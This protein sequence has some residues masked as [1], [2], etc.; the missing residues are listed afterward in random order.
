VIV[1]ENEP[2]DTRLARPLDQ[3]GFGLD[4][5]WN[6]D[7]HHSAM[8]ALTGRAEA[9]YSDTKGDVQELISA[10]K[11]GYLFQG[12]HYHW[13]RKPRGTPSRGLAPEAFVNYLQNHDQVANSARGL[14]G[15]QLTSPGAWRAMTALA[16][17]MPGTPM[18]FQGQE[19]SA[20]APFLYFA[21]HDPELAELV[22]KGRAEF[23]RQFPS[24]ADYAEKRALDDPADPDTFSRCVL[25]FSER[26][27]HGEA[28]ALH[29]DLLSLRRE[30]EVFHAQRAGA[31]DGAVLG[32]RTLVLR[33]FA[34]DPKAER[35][36]IVNLDGDVTRSS[37][38]EPLVAP[39]APGLDWV[40]RWSSEDAAYGGSGT[41]PI[42]TTDTADH[43]IVGPPGTE[44]YHIPGHSAVVL[45]PEAAM[46]VRPGIRRRTA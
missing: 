8:V 15:H 25:D 19:F 3:G 45:A 22:R 36:L 39:P 34:D 29:R 6:D 38:A 11:Y 43:E 30:D 32:P 20:S 2:Q 17:L 10:A 26:Q 21:D 14:R 40:V 4:G 12:Q 46:P 5:L 16:V 27:T 42:W 7:F 44:Q 18:L 1:A 23:L 31:V 41:P 35:L 13:Q 24:V 33:Y 28:Y 9:Y 37:F